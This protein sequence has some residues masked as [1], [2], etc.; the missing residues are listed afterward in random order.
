MRPAVKA[1]VYRNLPVLAGRLW[2]SSWT[3]RAEQS[4]SRVPAAPAPSSGQGPDAETAPSSSSS[5][6]TGPGAHA[7]MQT[8][9]WQWSSSVQITNGTGSKRRWQSWCPCDCPLAEREPLNAGEQLLLWFSHSWSAHKFSLT[10]TAQQRVR[11]PSPQSNRGDKRWRS[12]CVEVTY[13]T[14]HVY[15]EGRVSVCVCVC[16][17]VY[18]CKQWIRLSI[19]HSSVLREGYVKD[20]PVVSSTETVICAC[21]KDTVH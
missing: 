15:W 7:Q 18:A 1:R 9:G 21:L 10:H 5:L 20:R 17:C 4:H 12:V 13:C 16:V 11:E 6:Q 8:L 14:A 19:W 2:A 3:E